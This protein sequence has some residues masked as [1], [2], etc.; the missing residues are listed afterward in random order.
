MFSKDD[1]GRE[2]L[3][4]SRILGLKSWQIA[5]LGGMALLDC[6]V[7]VA[8]VAIIFN[9]LSSRSTNQAVASIP[10]AEPAQTDAAVPIPTVDASLPDAEPSATPDFLF[11]T[12]TPMGTPADSPTFTPSAT[13]SMEGWIK[14]SVR[15]VE[16][17]MPGSYAAGNPHTDAKAIVAS[18]KEMGANFNFETIEK[19]LTTSSSNYVL[20][21]IDSFQGNPDIM[22][23]VVVSY[24]FANLGESL[25]DYTTQ[26]I[27]AESGSFKLIE[28]GKIN[29]P[30][31]EIAQ[32]ILETNTSSA[33][34]A[35]LVLYAIRDQN[36][37]WNVIC[38]TAVDEMYA[39][40][41]VFD[42]MV[43]TFRVLAAPK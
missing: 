25:A 27:G 7:L 42:L 13:S 17:W 31:Y 26:F 9:S 30:L 37:F 2:F 29:S 12:F 14:V 10:T 16:L 5:A 19:N 4:L 35:R 3:G 34:P 21:G 22:T 6:L 28:Q 24:E 33:T 20:W 18:L 1:S 23:T 11:A 8:G 40:L 43:A 39:R 15:E 36:I 32:V 38:I 41:P